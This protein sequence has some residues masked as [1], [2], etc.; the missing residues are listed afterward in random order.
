[1]GFKK[2]L[3]KVSDKIEDTVDNIKESR[4]ESRLEKEREI[5]AR[6][7][8]HQELEE[9]RNEIETLLDKFTIKQLDTLCREMIGRTPDDEI[10][11]KDDDDEIPTKFKVSLSFD[12][13]CREIN[14]YKLVLF[15]CF[16]F[17]FIRLR[18]FCT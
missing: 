10:V 4:E 18:N 8:R 1:M 14:F 7:E 17:L 13:C 11:R 9:I 2:F 3:G 12:H 16:L 6:E 5:Q 15:L